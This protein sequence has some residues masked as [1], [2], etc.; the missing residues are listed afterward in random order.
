MLNN[1]DK[2]K[3]PKGKKKLYVGKYREMPFIKV[4]FRDIRKKIIIKSK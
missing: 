3:K 4:K 1:A 2:K